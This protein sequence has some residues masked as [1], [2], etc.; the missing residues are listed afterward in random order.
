MTGSLAPWRG[1]TDERISTASNGRTLSCWAPSGG[2]SGS[3]AVRHEVGDERRARLVEIADRRAESSLI[4]VGH[5]PVPVA[6]P[7]VR[8]VEVGSG[9]QDRHPGQVELPE[10]RGALQDLEGG[11]VLLLGRAIGAR[12][13]G[14]SLA[15]WPSASAGGTRTDASGSQAIS[16]KVL[17]AICHAARSAAALGAGTGMTTATPG[18]P[19]SRIPPRPKVLPRR[20]R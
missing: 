7:G 6:L 3:R 15:R 19:E 13:V 11:V 14:E 10:G 17:T 20:A 12:P 1:P 16:K 9:S 18:P 4:G 5:E 8:S 2:H